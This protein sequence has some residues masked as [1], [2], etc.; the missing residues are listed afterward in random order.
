MRTILLA[1]EM[2]RVSDAMAEL[3][4][5]IPSERKPEQRAG[6]WI[7]HAR[8]LHRLGRFQESLK[9]AEHAVSTAPDQR[10][11]TTQ[12]IT[13]LA[14]LGRVDEIIVILE[15]L[16]ME[17]EAGAL[18]VNAM[19]FGW[20]LAAHGHPDEARKLYEWILAWWDN[21]APDFKEHAW[22]VELHADVLLELGRVSEAGRLYRSWVPEPDEGPV[23]SRRTMIAITAA[24]EGDTAAAER[25]IERLASLN[26][27]EAHRVAFTQAVIAASIGQ[28]A[29]SVAYLKRAFAEGARYT[30]VFHCHPGLARLRG[31]PPFEQLLRPL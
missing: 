28:K 2:N 22:G 25:E 6:Y 1:L 18:G 8:L 29:R 24:A 16:T 4:R 9:S 10:W 14:A 21:A 23:A 15:R 13:A 17:E 5:L 31:Y 7:T 19:P 30:D 27:E 11:I 12:Q 3:D 26:A 20:E